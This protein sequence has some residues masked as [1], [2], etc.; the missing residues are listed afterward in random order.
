MKFHV[1]SETL[2]S[3]LHDSPNM[4]SHVYGFN[5]GTDLYNYSKLSDF[6]R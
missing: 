2:N 5:L 3:C 1:S 4:L 6:N